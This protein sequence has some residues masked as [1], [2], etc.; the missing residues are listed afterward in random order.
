MIPTSFSFLVGNEPIKLY[1]QRMLE[2]KA[3]G[4]SL[5][6]AGQEGI[7]KGLFAYVLAAQLMS[8]QNGER[9][10]S[11][12]EKGQHPDIHIYRPEGKLGLHS[13]QSLRQLSEEVYLPPY[14][15][16]WKVFIIH[17]AERMLTYSANA[18]L[19]TFEEPPPRT[20]IILLSQS[21]AALLPTI[22]SRCR[23]L[24]F[25]PISQG[26]IE[27]VLAQRSDL[28]ERAIQSI[29]SLAHGSLGRALHLAHKGGDQS[30]LHLLDTLSNLPLSNYKALGVVV[31][32]IVEEVES[33]RKQAE[34]AAKEELLRT[35]GDYLSAT[36]QHSLEKEIEGFS[37][38]AFV[39]DAQALFNQLLAWHRDLHLL[40]LT[41]NKSYLINVDYAEQLEQVVQRGSIVSIEKVQKAIDEA[42]LA[43]QRSTSLNICLENL[44]LKLGWI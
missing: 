2:K 19:K 17:E 24:H 37:T 41:R 10:R 8:G 4:N 20:I 14:E 38:L 44:F 29:A 15:A 28:D 3:I 36:Q 18:L 34:E 27:Q 11:K 13:I 39:Q 30:R 6:F 33:S 9:H 35:S 23:T 16:D 25:Q 42:Q 26:D 7:G 12:I 32:R 5:L 22:V 31:E 21:Q 1:L 43:L 40:Q